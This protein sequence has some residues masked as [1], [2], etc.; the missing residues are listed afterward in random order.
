MRHPLHRALP[1]LA[2]LAVAAL[3]LGAMTLVMPTDGTLTDQAALVV[4]ATVTARRNAPAGAATDST[5]RVERLVKGVLPAGDLV[6][7][8]PGGEAAE[9]M[10]LHVHGAPELPVGSRALLFLVPRRDGTWG[11][12][13]LAAGVFHER[14]EVGRRLAVRDLAEVLVL[15]P[16]GAPAGREATRDLDA[17]GRW[18]ADRAAGVRRA[19]DYFVEGSI[20][21]GTIF[22]KYTY[23]GG[24]RQRWFEFDAGQN[25]DWRVHQ[26]GQP[27]QADGGVQAF[28][29]GI[30]AWND[31]AGTNIRYRYAGRTTDSSGIGPGAGVY[32]ELNT[33]IFEDP[34]D[35]ADG[36]FTCSSPGNGSGV[37]AIGGTWTDSSDPI[38]LRIYNADIVINDGAGCWFNTLKRAEQVYGHELGHT[39]GLGHSTVFGALMRATA[40]PDER[41]ATLG[42]DDRAA[43]FTLYPD[44]DAVTAPAAPSNLVAAPQ[45]S[46]SILLTWTDHA[47]NETTFRVERKIGNGAF[48]LLTSLPANTTSF[49]ALSLSPSTLYTFRVRA[50]N[51]GGSSA[52]SN[53]ASATTPAQNAPPAPPSQLLAT[54][55][56]GN[57]VLLTWLD[58]SIG[59]AGFRVERSSPATGWTLLATLSPNTQG[60]T[61]T[62]GTADTPYS[63]RVRANGAAGAG[64]SPFSNVA[65]VTTPGAPTAGCTAGPGVLCLGAGGRF[66]VQADW[67]APGFGAGSGDGGAVPLTDRSGMFWFFQPENIELIV[68][69]LDGFVG[70]RWVFY[71]ALSNV[72]YWVTVTD[73]A[74]GAQRT[75]HNEQGSECGNADTAAFPPEAAAVGAF[76]LDPALPLEPSTE[77]AAGPCAPGT[78]C[79]LDGRFEVTATWKTEVQ[80]VATP[81]PLAGGTSGLFWF[82]NASN[83]ELVVKALDGTV[84]G[85]NGRYWFFYGALSDVEYD[86]HVRDTVT[87]NEKTYHHA[88]TPGVVELCGDQDT[89]AFP[90]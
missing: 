72:E 74:T 89:N 15:D 45:S 50:Q 7:R 71:G 57:D 63:F 69:V 70:E 68:K 84:P 22:E 65:S 24:T 5:L 23:L 76:T 13:H 12:L 61:V 10:V 37:L 20:G 32:D 87:G 66:R 90:P 85:L 16:T 25:V 28:K 3:P 82:F 83:I 52:F 19:P 88:Y 18:V 67:R 58:N 64:S 60:L 39:L 2:L 77:A 51:G 34:N 86:I 59:E 62:G 33:I 9:G 41:G 81:V 4:E 42:D 40:Y 54:L 8:T 49:Q 6:L 55:G 17:F 14:R 31:D 43:I 27:G 30:T 53:Q 11:A 29:N 46:S 44:P 21:P 80:G 26:S 35:Q 48:S 78:L 56:Q 38:P 47:T 75:Y 73:T 79:L 1:L 36:S